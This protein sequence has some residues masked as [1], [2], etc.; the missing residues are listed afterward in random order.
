MS[1]PD[2]RAKATAAYASERDADEVRVLV[3]DDLPDAAD[4]L[5][6][7]L[8]YDGYT[9]RVAHEG[10][11]ALAMIAEF[12]PHCVILDVNMPG[13]DGNDLSAEL[14]RR[15]GADIV[16][17]AISGAQASDRRVGQ[18]FE[19]VDHYLKKP[20][21]PEALRRVLPPLVKRG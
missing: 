8:E 12:Q 13:L 4:T 18:T 9:V 16:L 15:H 6:A 19:R 2:S 21:D 20:L 11:E 1:E 14:R 10:S 17:I 3:V 5:A 7:V